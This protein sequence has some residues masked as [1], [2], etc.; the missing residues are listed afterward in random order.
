MRPSHRSL[1]A[2]ACPAA[3]SCGPGAAAG[4]SSRWLRRAGILAGLCAASWAPELRAAPGAPASAGPAGQVDIARD[5]GA[6]AAPT[7]PAPV[8]TVTR[9]WL[10]R[11]ERAF[12]AAVEI[13]GF[14]ARPI[15][16]GEAGRAAIDRLEAAWRTVD[17]SGLPGDDRVRGQAAATVAQLLQA[18]DPERHARLAAR[19]A[20]TAGPQ[21]VAPPWLAALLA[22]ADH[23]QGFEQWIATAPTDLRVRRALTLY[24]VPMRSC[25]LSPIE[26]PLDVSEP[27]LALTARTFPG[28]LAALYE[29]LSYALLHGNGAQF[30]PGAV[31]PGD[32]ATTGNVLRLFRKLLRVAPAARDDLVARLPRVIAATP[33][34]SG[35]AR[36]AA[37]L[38]WLADGAPDPDAGNPS[39]A[40]ALRGTDRARRW[41]LGWIR[42]IAP[43]R[44]D[45][46]LTAAIADAAR[47]AATPEDRMLAMDALTLAPHADG[48]EGILVAGRAADDDL[49][50]AAVSALGM[51]AGWPHR[52]PIP[53]VRAAVM[54]RRDRVHAVFASRLC[55][56]RV[57]HQLVT[58]FAELGETRLDADMA[59]CLR[60]ADVSIMQIFAA[61]ALSRPS[62]QWDAT[63]AAFQAL[64]GKLPPDQREYPARLA[65][66]LR[67][68]R[69]A[70]PPKATGR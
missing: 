17:A 7:A 58:I 39:L 46:A 10:E 30:P 28:E 66:E 20:A 29:R 11:V 27:M 48:L 16:T 36:Q 52:A 45:A 68:A 54:A 70:P 38:A 15:P 12:D 4:G 59:R 21:D 37:L 13:R 25:G 3:A 8:D 53:A 51:M 34:L 47:R 2:L 42:G 22:R 5:P 56:R 31:V 49:L 55:D 57:A 26:G 14:R 50:L 24:Y 44:L 18:Y 40:A 6:S 43:G 63:I 32:R 60:A 33:D 19:L 41:G 69:S 62:G 67:A 9:R 23:D 35:R 64:A 65:H 1:A 61:H